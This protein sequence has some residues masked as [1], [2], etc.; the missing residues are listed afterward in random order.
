[1][2]PSQP[3]FLPS[4]NR[5]WVTTG[6]LLGGVMLS[7]ASHSAPAQAQA[8][9]LRPIPTPGGM[10]DTPKAIVDEAWQIVNREYVDSAVVAQKWQ[11]IRKQL[12]SR[13]YASKEQAYAA[14]REA[15]K[16]FDDVYTR[17]MDPQQFNALNDQTQGELS[18]VGIQLDLPD[19]TKILTVDN[20]VPESPAFK[21]G[22]QVGDQILAINGKSTKDMTI[23]DAAGLIR[24]DVDTKVVLRI[25]RTGTGDFNQPITR[26]KIELQTVRYSLRE[27]GN[28]RIGYIRLGDFSSH[29]DR[30][31]ERAIKALTEQKADAFVLDLRNNPGGLLDQS[32]SISQ[33]W[34]EKGDIVKTTDRTNIVEIIDRGGMVK[35]VDPSGQTR[36]VNRQGFYQEVVPNRP[37]LSKLPLAVIVDSNSA[38]SAEILTGA[39]QDNKRATIVG[40]TTFGKALV[41]SVHPLASDSSGLAV[42]IAHYYTPNGTDISKKGIK[43]DITIELKEADVETLSKNPKLLGTMSDP[44]YAKAVAALGGTTIAEAGTKTSMTP[45]K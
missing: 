13:N 36:L 27:E 12:L 31:M 32:L 14:L 28:K 15:F 9:S 34:L 8:A 43:P 25:R 5:L 19:S 23:A 3:R 30:Q 24:G 41:Q 38:S 1:M 20:T 22:I 16:T 4:P 42:T 33:M 11:P 2:T 37:V 40:T 26:A 44:Q 39:L 10:K 18:G 45:T 17:F 21:A 6:L 29:A 35:T 7:F